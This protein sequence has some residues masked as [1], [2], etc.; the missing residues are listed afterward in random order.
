MLL[1]GMSVTS[2]LICRSYDTLAELK[3]VLHLTALST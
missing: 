3:T 2:A 1:V